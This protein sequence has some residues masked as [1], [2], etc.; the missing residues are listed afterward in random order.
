MTGGFVPPSQVPAEHNNNAEEYDGTSWTNV[1]AMPQYQ[2]YHYHDY[3]YQ[4]Q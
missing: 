4:Y 3:Q 1:T 2:A